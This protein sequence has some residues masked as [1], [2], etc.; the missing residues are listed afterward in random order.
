MN[1]NLLNIVKRIVAEMGE[2]ILAD[3][4]KLKALF[5][6][7]AKNEPK[8]D[9]V[10]FGRCIEIG[11]YQELKSAP[12]VN[13][14]IHRKTTLIDQLNTK[15][16][17]DKARGAD[18]L[19]LLE[20]VI[21]FENTTPRQVNAPVPVYPAAPPTAPYSQGILPAASQKTNPVISSGSGNGR[22]GVSTIWPVG[23][24]T[25][26]MLKNG[27]N[28]SGPYSLSQLEAMVINGQITLNY[29][30][31]YDSVNWVPVDQIPELKG[32]F[33]GTKN[34]PITVNTT[35]QNNQPERRLRHGFTSFYL[36]L[37]FLSSAAMT[38]F[39]FIELMSDG[40]LFSSL[41]VFIPL[42]SFNLWV[43]RISSLVTTLA[44]HGMINW[45]RSGFWWFC[46]VA[47]VSAFL[48][49]FG[50]DFT[51]YYLIANAISIG[52]LYGVL[53]FKNAY[54]AKSTWEQM[55]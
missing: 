41:G 40:S 36:W 23:S 47:A 10:A 26:Y 37:S 49:P 51:V 33:Y 6:G 42:S 16:G 8:E 9:R 25:G 35:V 38:F 12:S 1:T 13:E 52:I 14:R 27:N 19:E 15:Y 55:E 7:Y 43:T 44:L 21:F 22:Y 54:N 53:H 46:V 28:I 45:K 34:P 5:S 3:P 32:I 2:D 24:T 50:T 4:Q 17:I 20:M 11:S 48:N 39:W 30:V 31:S 18:A 29:M